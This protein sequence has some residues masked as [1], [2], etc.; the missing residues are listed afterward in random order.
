ME[1]LGFTEGQFW[2]SLLLLARVG[3]IFIFVPPF[4]HPFISRRVKTGAALVITF[5]LALSGI[6][7]SVTPPEGFL[8]M[9]A[10]AA[11]EAAIGAMLGLTIQVLF[12]SVLFGGQTVGTQMGF[13]AASLMDPLLHAQ[14]AEVGYFFYYGALLLFLAVGGDRMVI[15][16]FVG[17][18]KALPLGHANVSPT[19]VKALVF[20]SGE[21]FSTGFM[22]VA[23]VLASLFATSL[24][25]GILARS[26][27]QINMLMMGYSLK[28]I[29]GLGVMLFIMP[30]WVE[31]FLR[32]MTRALTMMQ[33]MAHLLGR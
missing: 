2:A 7:G 17:N 31:A 27:P 30:T 6:A 25:L 8:A 11:R 15:E 18:L 23:P 5:A 13:N 4:S 21:I 26:V 14:V 9:V 22:L 29:V 19:A 1:V 12:L 33:G 10:V 16:A 20:W 3:S 24:L 28:I 32:A